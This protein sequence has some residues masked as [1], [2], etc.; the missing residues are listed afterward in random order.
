MDVSA[1]AGAASMA[2]L[3]KSLNQF[4]VGAEVLQKTL[5]KTAAAQ[6]TAGGGRAAFSGKGM[7]IDIAV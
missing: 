1:A 2:V 4:E 3:A 5:E 7:H 6:G